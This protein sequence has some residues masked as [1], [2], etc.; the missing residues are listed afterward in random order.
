MYSTL[1]WLAQS[2]LNYIG[3]KKI[4]ILEVN[5]LGFSEKVERGFGGMKRKQSLDIFASFWKTS[6]KST[7]PLTTYLLSTFVTPTSNKG[8]ASLDH[9]VE[10]SIGAGRLPNHY[11][12]WN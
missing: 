5:F 8:L 6:S 7:S 11:V 9:T 1:Y 10:V 4:L 2:L 12:V 3:F